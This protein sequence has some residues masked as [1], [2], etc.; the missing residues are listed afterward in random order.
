MMLSQLPCGDFSAFKLLTPLGNRH[1]QDLGSNIDAISRR[2]T[3]E[4]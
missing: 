4:R 3:L 2:I 1:L